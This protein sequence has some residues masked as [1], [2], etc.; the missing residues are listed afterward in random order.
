MKGNRVL[1]RVSQIAVRLN[2]RPNASDSA[3]GQPAST[4]NLHDQGRRT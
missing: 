1:P 2:Q 3:S 4:G